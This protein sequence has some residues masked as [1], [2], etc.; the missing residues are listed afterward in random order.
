MSAPD[1]NGWLPIETAPKD[2]SSV[3]CFAPIS[4][5]RFR[6]ILVLRWDETGRHGSHWLTD[7]HSFVPFEPTHWQPLPAPPDSQ[8]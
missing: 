6:R 7:V 2:G 5:T 1:K 8:P 4:G 3:L